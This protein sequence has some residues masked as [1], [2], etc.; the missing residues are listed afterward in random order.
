ME[1]VGQFEPETRQAV[2][3]TY[4]SLETAAREAVRASTREMGF[5]TSEYETRVTE[6][7]IT[8][9]QNALFASLLIA[10]VGTRE[11]YENEVEDDI[12]RIELGSENVSNVAWHDV[13]FAETVLATTFEVD[14]DPAVGM[15][16]QHTFG[17]VY[18]AVL[19]EDD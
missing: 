6:D 9:A 14:P 2:C 18:R 19:E 3:E 15:L 4:E 12:E 8:A 11:E 16:R 10:H 5:D 1:T 7:A 13:P 17:Q